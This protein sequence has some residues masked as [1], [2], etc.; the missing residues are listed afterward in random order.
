MQGNTLKLLEMKEMVSPYSA[1]SPLLKLGSCLPKPGIPTPG[2]KESPCGMYVA[3]IW[4]SDAGGGGI[5]KG[6]G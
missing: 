2:P 4:C 3:D 6:G 1:L 5:D